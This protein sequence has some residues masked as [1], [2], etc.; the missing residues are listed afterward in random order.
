MKKEVELGPL[1]EEFLF[2]TEVWAG[3]SEGEDKEKSHSNEMIIKH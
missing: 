3:V 2:H 1:R